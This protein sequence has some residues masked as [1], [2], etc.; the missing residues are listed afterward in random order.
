MPVDFQNKL[1]YSLK[2]QEKFSMST[3]FILN[4]FDSGMHYIL[5]DPKMVKAFTKDK[6]NRIL[7][8]LNDKEEF[9]CAILPKKEGGHFINIGSTTCKK[10]K[11]KEGSKVTAYFSIDSSDYQFEMP[12]EF[13]EVLDS[14]PKANKIFHG[15][16]EGNQRGLFYLVMQVK[17]TDKRI[18]RA[19]KIVDKIKNGITSPRVILK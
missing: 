13:K 4:K 10:L 1:N 8:K 16:T 17:S 11:I 19:L 2:Q 18:E 6:N 15:L 3:E 5:L 12:E 14:D 9:H 7:C